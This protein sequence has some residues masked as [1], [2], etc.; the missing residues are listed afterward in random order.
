M[1]QFLPLTKYTFGEE[2]KLTEPQDYLIPEKLIIK[3]GDSEKKPHRN[4]LLNDPSFFTKT[5]LL[6]TQSPNEDF[7]YNIEINIHE[8]PV[9]FTAS[10]EF[11]FLTNDLEL[12]LR[13]KSGHLIK[14]GEW[15]IPSVNVHVQ[16]NDFVNSISMILEP[17]TY[18]LI[19]TQ[20]VAA[21]HLIQLL[22]NNESYRKRNKCFD[23]KFHIQSMVINKSDKNVSTKKNEEMFNRIVDV[24]PPVYSKIKVNKKFE[25][26]VTF[27]GPLEAFAKNKDTPLTDAFYLENVNSKTKVHPN[28]C[29]IQGT[30]AKRLLLLYK[31]NTLEKD[32]CYVLRYNLD[33]IQS[34]E[35]WQKLVDDSPLVHRFCTKSCDCNPFT[36]FNCDDDGKC[37]CEEPYKGL[38]CYQ[39]SDNH[40][41]AH[42]KCISGENCR[43]NF[44]YGYGECKPNVQGPEHPPNCECDEDFKGSETCDK[45]TNSNMVFPHCSSKQVI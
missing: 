13:D 44:C 16:D 33:V 24:E 28:H 10:V 30:S 19:I 14:Q 42:Y 20:N 36:D 3:H 40:I 6:S 17:G 5:G 37:I 35:H 18:Y 31:K 21:N 43:D 34:L 26:I 9:T 23:F 1:S 12:S 7:V 29:Y 8:H 11:D 22:N 32:Q 2:S 41:M 25:I 45:C 15:V 4:S 38:G 39:C 27:E